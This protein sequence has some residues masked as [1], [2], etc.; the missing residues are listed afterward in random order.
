[1]FDHTTCCMVARSATLFISGGRKPL[2]S[3]VPA[4]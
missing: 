3:R 2:K 1:M 4:I